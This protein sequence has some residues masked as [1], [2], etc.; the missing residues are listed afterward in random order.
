MIDD[1]EP[2]HYSID[3]SVLDPLWLDGMPEIEDEVR[4]A[5]VAA[6]VLEQGL[7]IHPKATWEISIVMTDD[8]LLQELN[9]DYRQKDRP[10]NVLSFP[11]WDGTAPALQA[12]EG[13]PL[14]LGDVFIARETL[15][16]EAEAQSKTALDHLRHLVIH[17]VLHLLGQDHEDESDAEIMESLEIRALAKLGVA[18]PYDP[19]LYGDPGA[20]PDIDHM[21]VRG[22]KAS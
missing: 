14:L 12:P 19:L 1:P 17:G 16:R 3:T 6:L 10:T 4:R 22:Q 5:A 18:N 11:A 15:L 7:P 8:A 2:S 20:A 13:A 9:R 21:P